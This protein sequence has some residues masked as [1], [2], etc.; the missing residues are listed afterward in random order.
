MRHRKNKSEC[1]RRGGESHIGGAQLVSHDCQDQHKG[2]CPCCQPGCRIA[3]PQT[4][5]GGIRK[6]A[7][8]GQGISL[9]LTAQ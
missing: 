3:D 1:A 2:Q 7:C 6:Q 5:K 9:T 4:Q 8:T